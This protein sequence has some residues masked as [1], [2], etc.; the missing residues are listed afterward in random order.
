MY[1]I[2]WKLMT[3]YKALHPWDDVHRLYVSRQEG[4]RGLATTENGVVASINK[5]KDYIE[6]HERR[7]ITV[8]RNNNDNMMFNKMEITRKQ[9]WGEKQ[10]YRRF[11]RLINDMS[12]EKTRIWLK[13]KHLKRKSSSSSY[14][15]F[16]K[17]QSYQSK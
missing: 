16:R 10:L 13:K 6:N 5:P 7:L 9:K 17:E 3:V 8:N 4:G 1:P 2:I 14:K 12:H 15:Q 11:K